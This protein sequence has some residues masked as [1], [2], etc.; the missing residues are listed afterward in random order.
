MASTL[1]ATVLGLTSPAAAD[2]AVNISVVGIAQPDAQ[3]MAKVGLRAASADGIDEI[4]IKLR[5]RD[6]AEPYAV[7]RDFVRTGGT[8]EAGTWTSRQ[9]VQLRRGRTYADA[10][11]VDRAGDRTSKVSAAYEDNPRLPP[12]EVQVAGVDADNV[13]REIVGGGFRLRL[14]LWSDWTVARV[15]ARLRPAGR[16]EV[17]A[18]VDEFAEEQTGSTWRAFRS[19][20]ELDL[21]VGDYEVD[22]SAFNGAGD[23]AERAGAG[24]IRQRLRTA[25]ADVKVSPSVSDI[26]NPAIVTGRIDY[27]DR[28]GTRHPLPNAK[29]DLGSRSVVAGPDGVFTARFEGDVQ[30]TYAAVPAD[31]TYARSEAFVRIA[32]AYLKTRVSIGVPARTIV[33]DR[34]T[35]AGRLERADLAGRWAGL[36][37]KPVVVEHL[38]PYLGDHI[39]DLTWQAR[40]GVDGSYSITTAAPVS[41]VWRV[42]FGTEGTASATGG[43]QPAQAEST[44]VAR[45]LTRISDF[46]AGPEPVGNGSFVTLKG[47]AA[48]RLVMGAWAPAEY[49]VVKFEFS[50]DGRRWSV[51]ARIDTDRQGTFSKQVRATRDGFWR[52]RLV[53]AAAD[54][55]SAPSSSDHV[56]VRHRT[57]FASFNASPEPVRKGRTLTV[58]G[59]FNRHIGSWKPGAGV[60][61]SIYFKAKGSGTWR[62]MA[63]VRTGPQG[64]FRRVFKA[65]MDGTWKASYRGGTT[66]LGASSPGDYVDV[67]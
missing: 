47:R 23:E 13:P 54:L 39:V 12:Y 57:A 20:S 42:R 25:F 67:R 28:A 63:A 29:V 56:D 37:G 45:H 55:D 41:G 35:V 1:V 44:S 66:Y 60:T 49:R 52:A 19:V 14:R 32:F 65:S 61:V 31:E 5:G 6:D 21:P 4:T 26:E 10:E 27:F 38:R 50:P 22:V 58:S 59:K 3:G 30:G 34:L 18:T 16:D 64:S 17:V 43:Y 15:V 2:A 7:L 40:T 11:V 62:R 36:A 24:T 8:D 46:D 48:R 53:A 9:A 51:M 33:G